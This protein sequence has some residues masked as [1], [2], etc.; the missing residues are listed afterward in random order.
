[1]KTK[2]RKLMT[3]TFELPSDCKGDGFDIALARHTD[4]KPLTEPTVL[5]EKIFC[6]GCFVGY[7]RTAI[8]PKRV[9]QQEAQLLPVGTRVVF[10]RWAAQC[11]RTI[12]YRQATYE[13]TARKRGSGNY[14]KLINHGYGS[15]P[16]LG[17]KYQ[18]RWEGAVLA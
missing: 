7:S 11:Y 4:D 8:A 9:T 6:N 18:L 15:Y 1:M 10:N 5:R 3:T 2:A 16:N 12:Y 13:V 17:R 14:L